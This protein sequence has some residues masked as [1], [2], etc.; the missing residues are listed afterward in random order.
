[1][2]EHFPVLESALGLDTAVKLKSS[3]GDRPVACDR[4]VQGLCVGETGPA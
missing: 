4:E 1:M 2:I 3:W